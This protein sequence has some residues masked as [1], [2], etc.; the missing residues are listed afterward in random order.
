MKKQLVKIF[1][2][3]TVLS[4]CNSNNAEELSNE[5]KT[6]KI[7]KIK[8]TN[9]KIETDYGQIG[10]FHTMDEY[11]LDENG[12]KIWHGYRKNLYPTLSPKTVSFYEHGDLM[13]SETYDEVGNVL[14]SNR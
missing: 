8:P 9:P 1:F 3:L 10:D 11:Y 14:T 6:D 5:S 4:S 13:W 7:E 12:V 2:L